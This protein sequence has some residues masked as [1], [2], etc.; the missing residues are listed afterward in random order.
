MLIHPLDVS[1]RKP[2]I[3]KVR[4]LWTEYMTGDQINFKAW[5]QIDS[6]AAIKSYKV[7]CILNA[8]GGSV[9]SEDKISRVKEAS[10]WK[11]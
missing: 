6:A 2:F 3:G 9:P 11:T 4:T 7:Y 8:L 10:H 1:L 5:D